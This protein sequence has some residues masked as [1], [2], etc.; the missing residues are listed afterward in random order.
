MRRLCRFRRLGDDDRAGNGY[1]DPEEA[2]VWSP[3]KAA[4]GM[5]DLMLVP[6]S[7]ASNHIRDD[8]YSGAKQ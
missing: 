8:P 7:S 1:F 5:S 4:S 2:P 6:I 3:V